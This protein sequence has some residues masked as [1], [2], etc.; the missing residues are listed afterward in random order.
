VGHRCPV[1]LRPYP[2]WVTSGTSSSIGR[3]ADLAAAYR[4]I[5]GRELTSHT[6]ND[7]RD[8]GWTPRF[9]RMIGA[10]ATHGISTGA[11]HDREQAVPG[12]GTFTARQFAALNLTAVAESMS[13]NRPLPEGTASWLLVL[14]S[15]PDFEPYS[16]LYA[17]LRPSALGSEWV[18]RWRPVPAKM[19][20]LAHAAGLSIEEA[21]T[22]HE[23]GDLTV[24]NLL[25]LASLRGYRFPSSSDPLLGG[26]VS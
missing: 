26:L 20:A 2:D 21:Q 5:I 14:S 13:R 17:L 18:D 3:F 19:A 10:I 7:L 8:S 16:D 4:G 22:Q 12:R 9:I 11:Y 25:M 1:R 15:H 6:A 23:A 24:G